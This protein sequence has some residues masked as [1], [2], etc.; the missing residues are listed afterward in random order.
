MANAAIYVPTAGG[1]KRIAT[2]VEID[3][4]FGEVHLFRTSGG[5]GGGLTD[6]ELRASPVAV[7]VVDEAGRILG[8]VVIDNASIPVT[9][10]FW[11]ATQPVSGPLTDAQLRATGVPVTGTFWQ[12]TQPVSGPL[13]D[14][15][16][17][18]AAVAVSGTF[19]QAT[20]PV[21]IAVLPTAGG[22]TLTFISVNQGGAGVLE[23][24][25]ASVSNKHKV[26]GCVLTLSADG[27]LKFHDAVGDLTGPMDIAAKGGFVLPTSTSPF[28]RLVQSIG[29]LV[30]QLLAGPREVAWSF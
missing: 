27:T 7:D 8:H 5:A 28:S 6:V 25:A 22:K 11:Q 30:S 24:A 16:L 9:G 15:Q 23:L 20:Q 1:E 3:P 13:T 17:R 4:E 10:T 2:F 19:W 18:A 21:S 12:A 14:A 26:M 29:Q